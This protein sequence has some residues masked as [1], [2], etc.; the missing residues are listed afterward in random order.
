MPVGFGSVSGKSSD[1]DELVLNQIS[2]GFG[3]N[4]PSRKLKCGSLFGIYI[5]IGV[6]ECLKKNH[7][8]CCFS[9]CLISLC[10]LSADA[11]RT[12]R[13][14]TSHPASAS[15]LGSGSGKGRPPGC[16]H[17]TAPGSTAHQVMTV[18]AF[19][20]AP[21]ARPASTSKY[22]CATLTPSAVRSE[23]CIQSPRR[24]EGG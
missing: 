13:T 2:E 21:R 12:D 11:D 17:D 3:T 4:V 20:V 8:L 16:S 14:G 5:W 24:R 15:L 23:R 22:R 7:N 18:T 1:G 9:G 10:V 6:N 19:R